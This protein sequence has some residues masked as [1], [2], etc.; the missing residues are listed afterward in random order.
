V[1]GL[2]GEGE[3]HGFAL[4][5]Q[6]GAGGDLGRVLTVRRPLVYRAL[7][8]LV[9]AGLARQVEV[10]RGDAGPE[11]RIHRITP[12]GRRVLGDWLE[13]P[14]DHVRDLRIDFLLKLALIERSGK[15]PSQLIRRQNQALSGKLEALSR[16]GDGTDHIDLWRRNSALAA[17]TFLEELLELHS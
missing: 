8:R 10:E 6:L 3:S 17:A 11:R 1:L 7:G 14:V 13:H 2:L 15:S 16:V 4:S 5:R 12:A 9:D